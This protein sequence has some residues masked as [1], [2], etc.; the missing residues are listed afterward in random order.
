MKV[1]TAGKT[2]L[3]INGGGAYERMFR[4][5]G[6][7]VVDDIYDADLIQFTGG[8]DVTPG[9]YGELPHP[10]TSYSR[11]RDNHEMKIFHIAREVGVPMAGICRGG[12]FLNVMNGGKMYQDVDRH[13]ISGTHTATD[14]RSG[15][16]IEVSSTHHQMMR[17]HKTGEV[18]CIAHRATFKEH[19]VK[20]HVAKVDGTEE[21]DVEVVLYKDNKCLCFQPH[22]EF[23]S[24][25][26]AYKACADYYFECLKEVVK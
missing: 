4:M 5:Y 22:P 8:A 24:R 6:W 10:A 15:S 26:P 23:V 2:V 7:E 14:V 20:D 12:Q 21:N 25:N 16:D 11:A 17:P 3:I 13:A 1:M 9:L 18:L 19:M